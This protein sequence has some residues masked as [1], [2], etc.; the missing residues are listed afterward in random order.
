MAVTLIVGA[1]WL[2][3]SSLDQ[4]YGLS[5]T[6][7]RRIE[8]LYIKIQYRSG[9]TSEELKSGYLLSLGL[10]GASMV[11]H[12]A[13]HLQKGATIQIYLNPL[14]TDSPNNGITAK[15]NKLKFIQNN[16]VSYRLDLQFA[17][18]NKNALTAIEKSIMQ[19]STKWHR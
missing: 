3:Y 13:D 1:M 8:N 11:I 6:L 17:K 7:S 9:P 4:K 16:P 19:F 15:V 2:I 14:N 5:H 12:E 18:A 10:N